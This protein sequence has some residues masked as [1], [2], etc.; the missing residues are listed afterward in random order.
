[1]SDLDAKIIVGILIAAAVVAAGFV[2]TVATYWLWWALPVV[3]GIFTGMGLGVAVSLATGSEILF[4]VPPALTI[5]LAAAVQG[6]WFAWAI[7]HGPDEWFRWLFKQIGIRIPGNPLTYCP[8][9]SSKAIST[10]GSRSHSYDTTMTETRRTVHY[11]SEGEERGY[12]E[13]EYEVPAVSTTT[14]VDLKCEACGHAW[15]V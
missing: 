13:T 15:T 8:K 14:Y 7:D 4:L 5:G 9:C 1:M 3:V 2:L 11:S 12:S 6:R 10:V